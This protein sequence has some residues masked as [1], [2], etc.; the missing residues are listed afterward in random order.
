M[1]EVCLKKK[2]YYLWFWGER[3]FGDLKFRWEVNKVQSKIISLKNRIRFSQI[4]VLWLL[5]FNYLG[6][7]LSLLYIRMKNTWMTLSFGDISVLWGRRM[8]KINYFWWEKND[9]LAEIKL[10]LSPKLSVTQI[11]YA[12]S[13]IP[14]LYIQKKCIPCTPSDHIYNRH[15]IR[16]KITYMI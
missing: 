4:I 6:V 13:F 8:M 3:A 2:K 15:L 5:K 16:Q 10:P 14:L 1:S 7:Y 12:L 9:W 11:K